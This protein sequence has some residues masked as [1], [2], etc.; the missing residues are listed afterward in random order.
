LQVIKN[1]SVFEINRFSFV[2]LTKHYSSFNLNGLTVKEKSNNIE[3]LSDNNLFK[4]LF[5]SASSAIAI[6]YENKIIDANYSFV[7]LFGYSELNDIKNKDLNAIADFKDK[8]KIEEYFDHSKKHSAT[9]ASIECLLMNKA[10]K[11]ITIEFYL[12]K[13]LVEGK[14]ILAVSA[15]DITE[16][17]KL[18]KEISGSNFRYKKITESID[19]FLFQ[20]QLVGSILKPVF[21][22]PAIKKLSGYTQEEFLYD[23]KLFLKAV[24]PDD[25][26]KVK[27]DLVKIFKSRGKKTGELEFRIITKEGNIVNVRVRFNYNRTETRRVKEVFGVVSDITLNKKAADELSEST[28]NLVR[29]NETKDKFL[30]IISHDLR[31]PF[32]SILGFADILAEEE[33][34]SAEER[35]QFVNYIQES[36]HSTLSLINTVF[37]L[38]RLQTGR[39][40]VEPQRIDAAKIVDKI[41]NSLQDKWFNKKVSL[42]S[43]INHPT[44]IL[45]DKILTE[46]IFENL[47][48]N[49]IKFSHP[50]SV[51]VVSASKQDNSSFVDFCV[52]DSGIGIEQENIT[53]LFDI[54]KR[55]TSEGTD[56]EKGSGFGLC[57]VKEI[58]DK[59]CGNISVKSELGKGT[60]FTFSLPIALSNILIVDN[61]KTDRLLYSKILNSIMPDYK[62]DTAS[63]GKE[64]LDKIRISQPALVITEHT[65]PIMNGYEFVSVLQKLDGIKNKPH[66]IVLS[67]NIDRL[68]IND[69]AELGIEFVFKK[70]VNLNIFKLALEKSLQKGF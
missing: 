38:V 20:F 18:L 11:D 34:L 8:S 39:T 62:I 54:D 42:V 24:H 68:T 7:K 33:D 69:Y 25:F 15:Y 61:N 55:F 3:I 21:C 51:V 9:P 23:S 31:S 56:G 30:S 53:K 27:A 70:P 59:H 52:K 32:S 5:Y 19:D 4:N 58:V 46:Q 2:N 17:I 37:D 50:E 65:M 12:D 14:D 44:N 41:I 10:G 63:D 60:E 67:S 36:A 57:F 22:T 13:Y 40:K 48:T 29:L 28:K 47:L 1:S 43:L 45:A 64:A 26:S 49:A 66:V 35:K 6:L 16:K